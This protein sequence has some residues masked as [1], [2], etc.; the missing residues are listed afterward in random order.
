MI[1]SLLDYIVLATML[2]WLT[3]SIF[4]PSSP[5]DRCSVP[6]ECGARR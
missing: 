2:A 4:G 3:L 1:R 6:V 5:N